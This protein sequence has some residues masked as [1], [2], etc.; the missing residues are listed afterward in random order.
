MPRVRRVRIPPHAVTRLRGGGR[1][2]STR[3]QWGSNEE[4]AR[5][6]I[7]RVNCLRLADLRYYRD[8]KTTSDRAALTYAPRYALVDL[9]Q[10]GE[11][12]ADLLDQLG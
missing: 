1:S 5:P 8:R 4:H 12:F 10:H 6:V 2:G 3:L 7:R 11:A 9:Q